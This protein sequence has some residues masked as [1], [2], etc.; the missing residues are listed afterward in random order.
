[1]S[2]AVFRH[3]QICLVVF[4]MDGTILQQNPS[5]M[6]HFG[7]VSSANTTFMDVEADGVTPVNRLRALFGQDQKLYDKVWTSLND[8]RENFFE[9]RVKIYKR[10]M[11]P[12]TRHSDFAEDDYIWWYMQL[13][14]F[15]DPCTGEEVICMDLKDITSLIEKEERLKEMRQ[16]E[17]SILGSMIPEHILEFLIEEKR[18]QKAEENIQGSMD[19]EILDSSHSSKSNEMLLS[20]SNV[21]DMSDNRVASLAEHHEDVTILFTDIV[22]F[23]K[24]SSTCSPAEVMIML[25]KLFS[26]FDLVSERHN[27]YKVE[28]IGDAYMCAAGLNLKT[29]KERMKDSEDGCCSHKGKLEVGQADPISHATRMLNFAQD[30][31]KDTKDFVLPNE[32]SLQ[33]RIGVHTGDCMTGI[34]GMKMPRFCLFGDTVNTA[35]R[36]ESSGVPGRIH[37][38]NQ[39]SLCC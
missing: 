17:H 7:I 12:H 30:I 35:S 10:N 21:Q 6:P 39:L 37:G 38:K 34:V 36:M 20:L 11:R 19:S 15:R 28:T 2:T 26:I 32:E 9:G 18:S 24:I 22:G 31:L 33:I 4:A 16:H 1:M 14:K 8:E 5:S 27:I 29:E 3:C 13:H 23:T 25:N